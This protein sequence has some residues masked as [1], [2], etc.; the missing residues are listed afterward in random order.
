MVRQNLRLVVVGG[1]LIGAIFYNQHLGTTATARNTCERL[2][3]ANSTL[4][5]YILS[6]IA[7][8]E[9]TLPTLQYYQEHPD[10][11]QDALKNIRQQKTDTIKAFAPVTC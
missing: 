4:T 10:E 2:N 8:S 1:L 11:L 6:Q 3:T 5:Q 9:K 7:R